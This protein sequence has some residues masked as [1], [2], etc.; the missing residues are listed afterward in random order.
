MALAFTGKRITS[1][2]DDSLVSVCDATTG[3]T[4]FTYRGH[5][6][7]VLSVAWSPNGKYFASGGDDGTVQVWLAA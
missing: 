6:N 1:G 7:I 5:T 4:L 2:G 3:S